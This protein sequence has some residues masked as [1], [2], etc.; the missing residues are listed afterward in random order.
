MICKGRELERP[1]VPPCH[2]I[3]F[4]RLC[5]NGSRRPPGRVFI[6]RMYQEHFSPTPVIIW[7]L[8]S[9][10]VSPR[11]AGWE[12]DRAFLETCVSWYM[13][14]SLWNSLEPLGTLIR[15]VKS[16]QQWQRPSLSSPEKGIDAQA[17][18]SVWWKGRPVSTTSSSTKQCILSGT[19]IK[20]VRLT[21]IRGNK[22][23]KES[24][25]EKE[26]EKTEAFEWTKLITGWEKVLNVVS[27]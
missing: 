14:G 7:S 12:V 6:M 17:P 15:M 23:W 16:D 11:K 20:R 9:D 13:C 22:S 24:E 5:L 26:N 27:P 18:R 25:I 4:P 1:R 10:P 21:D 2:Q 3:P 19:F 8:Q